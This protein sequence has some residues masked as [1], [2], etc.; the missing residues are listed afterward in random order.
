MEEE[1]EDSVEEV[2]EV[3]EEKKV[4]DFVFMKKFFIGKKKKPQIFFSRYDTEEKINV[5]K[6]RIL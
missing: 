4:L 3:K 1:K 6:E 2:K 5:C